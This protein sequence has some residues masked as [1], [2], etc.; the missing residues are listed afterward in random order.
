MFS[1][2]ITV[3]VVM[4]HNGGRVECM[5]VFLSVDKAEEFVVATS[6]GS[7]VKS[8]VTDSMYVCKYRDGIHY[9]TSERYT[10]EERPVR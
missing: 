7:L 1:T 2:N 6:S 4:N 8:D 5:G 3:W 10:I 9:M